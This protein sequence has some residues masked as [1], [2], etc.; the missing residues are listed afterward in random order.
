MHLLKL[1]CFFKQIIFERRHFSLKNNNFQIYTT[2]RHSQR[3]GR[4]LAEEPRTTIKGGSV[5]VC[6]FNRSLPVSRVCAGYT[7]TSPT[8]TLHTQTVSKPTSGPT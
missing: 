6:V 2:P 8:D 4:N 3:V 7:N 5:C 1:S